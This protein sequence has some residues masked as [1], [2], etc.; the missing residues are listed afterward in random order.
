MLGGFIMSSKDDISHKELLTFSNLTNLN[1][2]FSNLEPSVEVDQDGNEYYE[3]P[4]LDDLLDPEVFAR[5]DDEGEIEEYVYMDDVSNPEE[6]TEADRKQGLK[7]L[8]QKA[9]IAMEYSE[10]SDEGEPGEFLEDWEVI[11]GADKYKVMADYLD[12]RE[13]LIRGLVEDVTDE[14]DFELDLYDERE[15]LEKLAEEGE[16]TRRRIEFA[17][18]AAGAGFTMMSG[19]IGGLGAQGAAQ[20]TKGIGESVV[21]NVID[22]DLQERLS[23]RAYLLL[24][25]LAHPSTSIDFSQLDDTPS[26]DEIM[27]AVDGE[28]LSKELTEGME[29]E[30]FEYLEEIEEVIEEHDEVNGIRLIED[31]DLFDEARYDEDKDE[32]RVLVLKKESSKL[33][34][35]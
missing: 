14:E 10:K 32:F 22:E 5:R 13:A 12:E 30:E 34:L 19:Y 35:Q 28:I 15:E 26:L 21:K 1:W 6:V 29:D 23:P 3:F 7:N 11:Y 33:K 17:I 8:R 27:G 24:T 16:E 2:E 4:S 31:I 9:G 20:I 18:E 25:S